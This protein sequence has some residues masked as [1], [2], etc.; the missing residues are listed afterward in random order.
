M[1]P[2]PLRHV[3]AL[4]LAAAVAAL[5][6]GPVAAECFPRAPATS[7]LDI[8]YAIAATVE[9][10][11]LDPDEKTSAA[12]EGDGSSWTVT[13]RVDRVHRGSVAQDELRWTGHT[14]SHLS[15][16]IDLLGDRLQV[17]DR[18]FVAAEDWLDGATPSIYGRLL[19][20]ERVAGAWA[21]ADDLLQDEAYGGEP[22]PDAARAAHTTSQILALLDELPD[23]AAAL[24]DGATISGEPGLQPGTRLGLLLL[25]FAV[26]LLQ[27][28]G[29]FELR[30]AARRKRRD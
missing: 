10:V 4:V 27:L 14:L 20:W 24:A 15:C 19:A 13:V 6:A 18:L 17:G 21:F 5:A 23:T 16:N 29:V 22:Y 28:A 7:P 2:R 3:A 26:S 30:T 1:L 8:D 12:G 11:L 9:D 25:V